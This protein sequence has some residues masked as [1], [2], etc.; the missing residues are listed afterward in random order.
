MID[1]CHLLG[2]V[3]VLLLYN[4]FRVLGPAFDARSSVATR[5]LESFGAA[6]SLE[7]LGPM[8]LPGQQSDVERRIHQYRSQSSLG[9]SQMFSER[10][11]AGHGATMSQSGNP[12][13]AAGVEDIANRD[14]GYSN[15]TLVGR[16]I[17]P[18]PNAKSEYMWDFEPHSQAP[19]PTSVHSKDIR[20]TH[21]QNSSIASAPGLPVPPRQTRSPVLRKPIPEMVQTPAFAQDSDLPVS[22]Q[23]L[24]N[25]PSLEAFGRR[26]NASPLTVRSPNPAV[27]KS[28]SESIYSDGE[29]EEA[30]S[31]WSSK[32]LSSATRR[33]PSTGQ[34]LLSPFRSNYPADEEIG[35]APLPPVAAMDRSRSYTH[36]HRPSL[37]SSPPRRTHRPLP[38]ITSRSSSVGGT[39][40]NTQRF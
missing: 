36:A 14:S 22:G 17:T 16:T 20:P 30:P 23:R 10:S 31:E 29:G 28:P 7:K 2:V 15:A 24:I 26:N 12:M 18:M 13:G 9:S 19:S 4:T 38:S 39:G 40:N 32:N 34:P 5:K 25:Q 8:A 3:D 21:S 27:P 1:T 11:T 35:I 6:S 33:H 37:S